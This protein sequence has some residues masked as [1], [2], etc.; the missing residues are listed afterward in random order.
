MFHEGAKY[1]TDNV[2]CP[3]EVLNGPRTM[4][5]VA[6]SC[7]IFHGEGEM[8]HGDARYSTDNVKCSTEVLNI[9]RTMSN[10]PRRC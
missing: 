2:Q 7:S 6:R 10:I 8:F 5:N 4:S 9:P 3:T 1:S